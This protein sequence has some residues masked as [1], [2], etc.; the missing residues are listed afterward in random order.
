M[1]A[2]AKLVLGEIG[3]VQKAIYQRAGDDYISYAP[4]SSLIAPYPFLLM[5][6]V[7]TCAMF[8]SHPLEYQCLLQKSI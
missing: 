2:Q 1:D 6:Y 4:L 8:I 5:L 3:G 7:A